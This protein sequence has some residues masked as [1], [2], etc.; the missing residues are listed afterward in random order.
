VDKYLDASVAEKIY[1]QLDNKIYTTDNTIWF[2]AVVVNAV[3]HTPATLSGVLYVE[4]IGPDERIAEKKLIKIDHGTGNGF[5]DLNARY[6][7]GLYLVRAYTEWDKNFGED[8]FFREYIRVFDPSKKKTEPINNIVLTETPNRR[9]NASFDP[10][11]IDSLHKKDLTLFVTFDNKKDS[12]LIKKNSKDKYLFDYPVPENCQFITFQMQ[13]KNFNTC[14]KTIA[15]DENRLDLQFFPESG[16]LVH[17]LP[18]KVAFKALDYNGKGK[19]VEGEIINQQGEVITQFKSNLLGM[20]SFILSSADSAM[21]Y[22]ARLK[23]QPGEKLTR[24]YPLPK[25]SRSG[26]VLS[27]NRMKG[28]I[29][30]TAMSND[31]KNDSICVRVSC[32]G[33]VYYDI[34]ECLK[35]GTRIFKTSPDKLPEGIIAF[36]LTDKQMHPLAERL[37]FNEQPESRINIKLNTDKEIYT[38]RQMTKLGI[39][40]TGRDGKAVNAS[41]SLLVLNK[42]QLG[43]MQSTRQNILSYLLLG[44]DLKGEI[45]KPGFYFSLDQDRSDDLDALMLTQGW[46]KYNYTKTAEKILFLPE[47]KLSVSGS[48]GGAIFQ[49]AKKK[50][51]LTLMTFGKSRSAFTQ[52]TDSTGRFYFGLDDEYGQNLNVLIQSANKAGIKKNYTIT[53]DKKQSPPVSFNHVRSI[54][55]PDS[56]VRSV[57]EKNIE[58]KSVEDALKMTAGSILL[59]EVVVEGTQMTPQKK[60]VTE[61]Y[62]KPKAVIS[63]DAIREKEKKWSF[64]LYSILMYNYPGQVEIIRTR[65]GHLYA[66]LTANREMTLVVID[67]IPVSYWDYSSIPSIPPSEVKSLEIIPYA[68]NFINLFLQVFPQASAMDAPAVGNVI[69]I[70]T[71][72]GK[73]IYGAYQATGI[74]KTTVPVFSASREFYAPKYENTDVWVRPDLRALVHWDPELKVDS[75]GKAC[76]TFYN[77]DVTGKMKVVVEAI[78]DK[79]EI[80]YQELEYGVERGNGN[81]VIDGH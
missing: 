48:V 41:L 2:K 57:V 66:R 40:T 11:S 28:E 21:V 3:D 76:A 1:L 59:N 44:S 81:K 55:K 19:A 74:M 8:F 29:W 24:M 75:M 58:R 51:E 37:F 20:G 32:R 72:G 49:K 5:F 31:L 73:G 67:G 64:G 34:K 79:G 23:S 33:A 70:Y 39:E 17:G 43:Q 60:K 15:L 54:E 46:R 30:F 4:L 10:L 52:K 35:N 25:V 42:D 12:F 62:G 71:Y 61:E 50:A 13:T 56:T 77:A 65:S 22:S 69:A 53:L 78:S 36:T 6:P 80:G 26:S 7:E 45:E 38:Q 18:S 9:I 68:K 14:S 27:V 63:G 16:E 47:P